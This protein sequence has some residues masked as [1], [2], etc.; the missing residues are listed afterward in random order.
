MLA[1]MSEISKVPLLV[2]PWAPLSKAWTWALQLLQ[3]LATELV[4][5]SATSTVTLSALK[6]GP[7]WGETTLSK[8][9]QQ[10]LKSSA[11]RSG[12]AMECL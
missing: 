6:W 5:S 3:N 8:G 10:E 2:L 7:Q 12:S 1:N 11:D 4:G 9:L